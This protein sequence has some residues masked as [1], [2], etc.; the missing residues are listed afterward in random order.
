MEQMTLEERISAAVE[1]VVAA[2]N[3]E[4]VVLFGSAA[5]GTAGPDSD[6]D[7]LVIGDPR[8]HA[9]G[10]RT[11]T[12]TGDEVDVFVT[13]QAS[14]RRYRYSATYLEGIALGEGRTVYAR[15][16]DRTVPAGEKMIKRTLYD[17]DKAVEWVEK[18]RSHLKRFERDEEDDHKCQSLADAVE[19]ALKALIVAGGKR[20]EHRHG[21]ER[22]WQQ[23]E[24][25]AGPLPT[26]LSE[27]DLQQLTK[28]GGEFRYPAPGS[29]QLDPAATWRRLEAPA[30][31]IVAHAEQKVPPLVEETKARIG[32]E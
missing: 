15:D 22:L 4:Q 9:D 28:H 2:T 7:L 26:V 1:E 31:T 13:D 23:A 14:A 8:R 27:A 21:L 12:R 30:Q 10:R 6:I 20:V 18:A 11:C 3:P 25:V 5:K 16:P 17:P 29:R 19:R 32:E 24:A